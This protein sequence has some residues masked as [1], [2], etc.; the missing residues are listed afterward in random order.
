MYI[1]KGGST[2]FA[3]THKI[4]SEHVHKNIK[5]ILGIELNK[6]NLIYGSIKPDISY[7]LAKLDHFKPQSFNF[8]CNEINELSNYDFKSNK[9]FIKLISTRIGIATHFISD[10]FC[11][12]HN[13]RAKYENNFIEH[14]K[15]ENRLHK[16]FKNF[17]EKIEISNNHFNICNYSPESIKIL[18]DKFHKQYEARGES[19][20]NDVR[21][22]IQI[23]SIVALFILYNS[24][25]N[26]K[27]I[28]LAS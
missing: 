25:N 10:F 5:N 9:E 14:F 17:D 12:P 15:Y 13:D 18:V 26:N 1:T 19:P 3:Q 21:S 24:L 4:I 20:L 2:L 23:S 28:S 11:I 6:F 22:S 7:S 8:V 16:L 27:V